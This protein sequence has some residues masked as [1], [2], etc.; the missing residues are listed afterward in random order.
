[1]SCALLKR[2]RVYLN[3]LPPS[4]AGRKLDEAIR[5]A[6]TYDVA[7]GE[8][9]HITFGAALESKDGEDDE[10]KGPLFKKKESQKKRKA[11]GMIQMRQSTAT[12]NPRVFIQIKL[13]I[14]TTAD[15]VAA[16]E[17]RLLHSLNES[18]QVRSCFTCSRNRR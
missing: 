5:F 10:E 18:L 4:L 8:L 1:L 9:D 14:P 17:I 6:F 15:E 3:R 11:E 12:F 13:D 2:F 16:T 7:L